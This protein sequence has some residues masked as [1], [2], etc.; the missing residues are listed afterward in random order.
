MTIRRA[1]TASARSADAIATGDV[2]VELLFESNRDGEVT[3][4]RV[5]VDP[6][7]VTHWHTHPRGQM[8]Y[9]LSGIGLVSGTAGRS[10]RFALATACGSHRASGIGMVRD[11]TAPSL[12]FPCRLWKTVRR[13][14]GMNRW[15]LFA[16]LVEH[17]GTRC[18]PFR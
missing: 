7:V 2:W 14:I 6:G 17:I 13:F 15:H 9:V 1:G 8:L 12:T 3:M 5:T 4:M 11:R 10:R 16:L 18:A